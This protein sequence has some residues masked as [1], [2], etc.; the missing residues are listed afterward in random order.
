MYYG[1][2]CLNIIKTRY[3]VS[4]G[5]AS[6]GSIKD[7]IKSFEVMKDSDTT[8]PRARSP[9]SALNSDHHRTVRRTINWER[10]GSER[11]QIRRSERREAE[12]RRVSEMLV[13]KEKHTEVDSSNENNIRSAGK[14]P[15]RTSERRPPRVA[16]R[17]KEK[18]PEPP[19]RRKIQDYKG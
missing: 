12:S 15:S 14:T 9:V 2:A 6:L 10:D 17:Y 8:S 18:P 16:P 7:R 13:K 5:N 3:F 1:A 11:R 19:L 4:S